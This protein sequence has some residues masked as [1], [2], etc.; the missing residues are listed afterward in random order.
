MMRFRDYLRAHPEERELYQKT[1]R[2]VASRI[3]EYEQDYVDAKSG[4]INEILARAD[5][6]SGD[7]VVDVAVPEPATE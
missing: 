1:K 5:E 3:W 4:V 7:N 6:I 2:E